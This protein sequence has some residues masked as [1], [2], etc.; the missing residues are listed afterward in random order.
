MTERDLKDVDK[1]EAGIL[2]GSMRDFL[3]ISA[4]RTEAYDFVE[5]TNL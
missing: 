4:S 2:I 1:D 5:R 3:G